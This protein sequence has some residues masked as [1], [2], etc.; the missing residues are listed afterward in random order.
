MISAT[1]LW[2]RPDSSNAKLG[3]H[4][5]NPVE[6]TLSRKMANQRFRK[7][8]E[9]ILTAF[10]SSKTPPTTKTL[11][12]RAH[13]SRSTFYRHHHH[14]YEIIP[15]LEQFVLHQYRIFIQKLSS[16]TSLKNLYLQTLLF[17]LRYR[18]LF[19][20]LLSRG[21]PQLLEQI[22][23]VLAP[24]IATRNHLPSN[25]RLI[26]RVHQKELAGV[27]EIWLEN[28][29]RASE[30]EVL[31]NLLYLTKTMR[32]RLTNLINPTHPHLN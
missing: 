28:G 32:Q 5:I 4:K 24:K 19:Q 9:A 25:N 2:C 29:C 21:N 30:T 16:T 1:A 23:Q 6:S 27:V 13:I 18:S 14:V 7:T 10:F 8:E 26:L 20:V 31:V 17:I 22:F 11:V 3:N 12:L 15:D